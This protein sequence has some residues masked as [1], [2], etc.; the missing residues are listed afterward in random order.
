MWPIDMAGFAINIKFLK[1]NS[2]M[3]FK[4]G[5]EE[6]RFLQSNLVRLEDIDPKASNCTEILVWHTQ[7]KRHAVSRLIMDQNGSSQY[8]NLAVLIKRVSDM[9]MVSSTSGNRIIPYY[10]HD[11]KPQVL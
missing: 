7:T 4:A 6:D 3:P 2:S 9:A 5:F 10:T 1:A 11:G 8:S